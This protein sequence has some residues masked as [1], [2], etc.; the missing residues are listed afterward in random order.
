MR[1]DI[2]VGSGKVMGG[3][4]IYHDCFKCAGVGSVNID[5]DFFIAKD[6]D[7][8]KSAKDKI[9][10]LDEKMT[11]EEAEKLLDEELGKIDEKPIIKRR[12]KNKKQKR[13]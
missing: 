7:S 3:G 2:C 5:D 13:K 1:C 11:D 10:A 12:I 4:M 9:K 8:Y 6:S